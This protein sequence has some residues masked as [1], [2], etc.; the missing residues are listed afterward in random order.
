MGAHWA[1]IGHSLGRRWRW[2]AARYWC[3]TQRRPRWGT[4]VRRTWQCPTKTM[5]VSNGTRGGKG[6]YLLSVLNPVQA[7]PPYCGA[8]VDIQD[9]NVLNLETSSFNLS[10]DPPT[11]GLK[12]NAPHAQIVYW[13]V[14]TGVKGSPLSLSAGIFTATETDVAWRWLCCCFVDPSKAEKVGCGNILNRR[15]QIWRGISQ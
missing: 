15:G 2:L 1:L 11:A 7:L 12:W 9:I 10:N 3:Y 14:S 6:M 5:R 4:S 13:I 8:V